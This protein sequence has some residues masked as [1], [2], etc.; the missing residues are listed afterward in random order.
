MNWNTITLGQYQQVYVYMTDKSLTDIEIDCKILS[1]LTGMSEGKIDRMSMDEFRTHRKK[2]EFLYSEMVHVEPTT[3]LR[4]QG[5]SFRVNY[6]LNKLPETAHIDIQQ[7]QGDESQLIANLHNTMASMVIPVKRILGIWAV[8]KYEVS[9]RE[10]YAK[11]LQGAKFLEVYSALTF[12]FHAYDRWSN[13]SKDCV[14][15]LPITLN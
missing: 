6:D 5:R 14:E 13:I 1:T 4:T 11:E 12:I 7:L 9:K 8:D 15:Q 10:Q 3:I 2:I